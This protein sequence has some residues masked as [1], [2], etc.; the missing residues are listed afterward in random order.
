MTQS[1]QVKKSQEPVVEEALPSKKEAAKPKTKL[2][3]TLDALKEK[4]PEVYNQYLAAVKAKR[5]VWVYPDLTV[6]IG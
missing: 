5:P 2:D 4:K 1:G 3:E 6:R